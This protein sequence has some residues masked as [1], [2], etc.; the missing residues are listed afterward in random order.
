M[1]SA[2]LEDVL[3]KE[4]NKNLKLR[5][6]IF[7]WVQHRC[8]TKRLLSKMHGQQEELLQTEIM[9]GGF[10]MWVVPDRFGSDLNTLKC[11]NMG[12]FS[13]EEY[14][15]GLNCQ[16]QWFFFNHSHLI[17]KDWHGLN[18]LVMWCLF[19]FSLFLRK[20]LQVRRDCVFTHVDSG[21]AVSQVSGC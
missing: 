15:F 9:S 13:N 21:Q 14:Y 8:Q 20:L 18:I 10:G 12:K 7:T 3:F 17:D 11:F 2:N 1:W 19:V 5:R 6:R 16:H 4:Q